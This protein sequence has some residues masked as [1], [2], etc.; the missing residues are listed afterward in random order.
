LEISKTASTD[1]NVTSKLRE[2]NFGCWEGLTMDEIKSHYGSIY[3]VWRERAADAVIPNGERLIDLQKRVLSAVD[4]ILSQ[5]AGE[6]IVIVSHGISVKILILSILG[7]DISLHSR[8][9][10]DNTGVSII[11]YYDDIPVL[12]QLN[13]ICHLK[14]EGVL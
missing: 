10:L 12:I 4:E 14:Q 3:E 2:M 8:I 1:I 13:D 11:D 6:N 9:R 5:H 7:M